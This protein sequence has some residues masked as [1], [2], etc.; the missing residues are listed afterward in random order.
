MV[1]ALLDDAF[2]FEKRVQRF[3]G[4]EVL[5]VSIFLPTCI[6]QHSVLSSL[7]DDN[8]VNAG[9]HFTQYCEHASSRDVS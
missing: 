9:T 8:H 2:P 5:V 1:L 6:K 3:F 4:F 7:V